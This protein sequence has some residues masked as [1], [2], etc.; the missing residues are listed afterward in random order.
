MTAPNWTDAQVLNQL[1]SG[2]YWQTARINYAFPSRSSEL[3]PG[4]DDGE[5]RGFSPFNSAQQDMAHLA[6]ATW[7]DL[8]ATPIAPSTPANAY[9]HFGYTRTG[10][11]F[12]HAYHPPEGSIWFNADD[13]YL[14]N[15]EPGD[16]G[17]STFVHEIGH[18]LGLNHMGDYDGEG[19]WEPSA[20]QDS[21]VY[22]I[23]SYMGPESGDGEGLVAWGNWFYNGETEARSPQTPMINDIMAIQQAY[24]AG[25]TR[26]DNSI[27]GFGSSIQGAT[28]WLYDFNL[29]A[30]PIL[31]FYDA[32]GFDTL[33]LSGWHSDSH[34]DLTPGAFSSANGMTNNLSIARNTIIEAVITGAGDDV[35]KGNAADNHFKAGDGKNILDGGPGRDTAEY[36]WNRAQFTITPNADG[37]VVQ[38]QHNQ[39]NQDNISQIEKLVFADYS[40]NLG[41]QAAQNTIAPDQLSTLLELYVAFFNRIPEA[42]GVEYWVGKLKEGMSWNSVADSFY[43]AGTQYAHL[44]GY[45]TGMTSTDFV[46]VVYRNVLGRPEGADAEGLAYWTQKLDTGVDTRGSLVTSILGSAHTYK[47]NAEW[48]WVADLLDNKISVAHYFAVEQGLAYLDAETNVAKGMEIAAAITPTDTTAALQI[49]GVNDSPFA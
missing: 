7:A 8:I 29:N 43:T 46:N 19:D 49:I 32:G 12:A 42:D 33:N 2:D 35:L 45:S 18:A 5:D 23:M 11:E 36:T 17:F 41:I 27:Y 34:I 40:V 24:G 38:N 3:G 20:Y 30:A 31:A 44:T 37:Y 15:P 10:I 9:I 26:A 47:G 4:M 6:M 14:Q 1:L 25:N 28:A 13:D 48:G 39:G 21:V 22:S 16:Y